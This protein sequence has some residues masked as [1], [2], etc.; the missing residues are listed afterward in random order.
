MDKTFWATKWQTNE[1]GF[2]EP[3]ANPLLIDHI[4]CLQLSQGSRVFVPLCGKTLDIAWLLS[5]DYKIV[6]VELIEDAIKQLFNELEISPEITQYKSYKLY[7]SVNIDIFVGDI[8]SL[9]K[10]DLGTVGAVYDRAAFVALPDNTRE[11]YVNQVI[12]LADFA[13][14]LLIT[15]EYDT[16]VMQGPPFSMTQQQVKAYF[17]NNYA[18]SLLSSNESKDGLKGLP[19]KEYVWQLKTN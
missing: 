4:N 6:G 10:E 7:R 8:F 3:K 13:P 17:D 16:S 19:A 15:Y 11:Q 18:V 5:Q 9:S 1:I 12:E 2:H 14:Q